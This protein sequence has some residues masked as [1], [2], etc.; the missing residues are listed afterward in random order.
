[1]R[2]LFGFLLFASFASV[3]FAQNN[4]PPAFEIYADTASDI[5]LDD[6]SWQMLEDRE[7][8]WTI[9]EVSQPP[10]ADKFHANATKIKGV[11]YSINTFW[12]RYNF[13]NNMGHEARITISKDVSSAVLYTRGSDGKGP[14]RRLARSRLRR[15]RR[16][17]SKLPPGALLRHR[18]GDVPIPDHPVMVAL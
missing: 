5:R 3:A 1:M 18:H 7:G 12:L 2:K 13:K 17:L 9:D 11:D 15:L 4:L 6:S 10:V 8:K 14:G 16:N